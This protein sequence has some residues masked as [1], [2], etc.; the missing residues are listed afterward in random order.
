MDKAI[1]GLHARRDTALIFNKSY[2]VIA[3]EQ[4]CQE[5]VY[6]AGHFCTLFQRVCRECAAPK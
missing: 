3:G 5:A 2:L 6:V 4:V 1:C